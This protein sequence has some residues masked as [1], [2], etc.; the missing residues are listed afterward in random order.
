MILATITA[1]AFH[2]SEAV[3]VSCALAN[4][5]VIVLYRG[6][7]KVAQGVLTNGSVVIA[8]PPLAK[9]DILQASVTE[10]GN[11]AGLPVLVLD[12]TDKPT[13]WRIPQTVKISDTVTLTAAQYE[14]QYGEKPAA[15]YDPALLLAIVEPDPESVEQPT[16]FTGPILFSIR[17]EQSVGSTTVTVSN[18]VNQQGNALIRWAPNESFGNSWSRSFTQNATITIDV[19]GEGDTQPV[20]QTINVT[21]FSPSTSTPTASDI[22]A[23]SYR[24]FNENTYIRVN[25]NSLKGLECRLDGFTSTWQTCIFYGTDY[26]EATFLA[27]PRGTYTA[28]VRVAGDTDSSRWRSLV[29]KTN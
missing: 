3:T 20:S 23:I 7:Y 25:L 22:V 21:V 8:V 9:G 29:I 5:T 1:G 26:Q 11:Q 15:V 27:V 10:R 18:V 12:T 17:T 13:G 28:M 19:K 24:L 6:E 14:G 16:T 2:G 4:G